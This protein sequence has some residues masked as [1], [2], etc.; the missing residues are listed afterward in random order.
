MPGSRH[1]SA[2]RWTLSLP[3]AV[4]VPLLIACGGAERQPGDTEPAGSPAVAAGGSAQ[5]GAEQL[6]QQRCASCHQ[7]NGQGLAGA[8]PPL[9]GSEYAL[10][11]PNVPIR[12]VINGFQGPV[13]VKGEEFNGIMPAYG[14]G[15]QMSDEEVAS[16]L[17]YVRSSWGNNAGPVTPQD[18]ATERA[19]ARS[20]TGPV[21]AEELAPLMR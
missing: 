1:H 16:V 14:T 17:T 7:P 20:A 6:Y 8:F 4:L 19:A 21:T 13:T 10:A 9:A 2:T 3:T 12:I 18:V 11:S 5:T 15:I